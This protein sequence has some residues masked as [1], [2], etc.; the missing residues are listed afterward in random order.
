M[1]QLA[2]L[3]IA[4]CGKPRVKQVI[5]VWLDNAGPTGLLH[6]Q[7]YKRAEFVEE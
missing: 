6:L 4:Y 5:P 3:G 2:G 1:L 7:G